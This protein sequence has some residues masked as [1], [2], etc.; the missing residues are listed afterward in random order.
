MSLLLIEDLVQGAFVFP[1][2]VMSHPAWFFQSLAEHEVFIL[3][4]ENPPF[5]LTFLR[6]KVESV[7]LHLQR[8]HLEHLPQTP[9]LRRL[10]D[11]RSILLVLADQAG[12]G[13]AGPQVQRAYVDT[14]RNRA[15]ILQIRK[16]V[17]VLLLDVTL[18]SRFHFDF[19]VTV[20][21]VLYQ[22][23]IILNKVAF[24]TVM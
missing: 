15:G 23:L 22:K 16:A 19:H 17:L 3:A 24:K 5:I 4:L 18:K 11:Q 8:Y 20:D 2:S 1:L 13:L 9:D 7:F 12:G 14:R 6:T 10:S 21:F